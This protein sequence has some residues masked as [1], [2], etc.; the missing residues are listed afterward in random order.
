MPQGG[1]SYTELTHQVVREAAEPLGLD[2]IVAQVV[3]RAGSAPKN[4]K[5]TVRS[6]LTQS[7]AIVPLGDGRWGWRAR[8]IN[9]AVHR[10]ILHDEDLLEHEL[11][12]GEALRDLLMPTPRQ[13]AKYATKGPPVIELEGGPALIVRLG[14]GHSGGYPLQIGEFFWDWLAE[15]GARPGDSLLISAVDGEARRYRLRHEPQA[16][17][18]EATIRRRGEEVL[19]A[20]TALVRATDGRLPIWSVLGLLNARGAFHH[21]VPPEPFE[22]LWTKDVWGPLA[23]EL[24]AS[25]LLLGGLYADDDD[26]DDIGFLQSVLGLPEPDERPLAV[27]IDPAELPPGMTLEQVKARVDAL[28]KSP[29]PP[30]LAP[31]DPLLPLLG[32]VMAAAG[33]PSPTGQPYRADQL[34]AWFGDDPATL[35]WIA[36]GMALGMVAPDPAIEMGGALFAGFDAEGFDDEFAGDPPDLPAAYRRGGRRKP[37]PSAAGSKGPVTTYTLRVAYR[38]QPDFW[39]DIEIAAD[40][41]LEDLHLAI[42]QALD[43]DDDHLYSFYTGRRPYDRK[44]E[45]GSPWSEAKRHTH[46]VELGGLGLAK[47]KRLLYHFDYGDD[48]LFDIEVLGVNAAAPKGKYPK[49]VGRRGARLEQYPDDEGDWDDGDDEE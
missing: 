18:D 22:E 32:K 49:V 37:R 20:A 48:H 12:A 39:R 9:G 29:T 28:L 13:D 8:L 23:D 19:A 27:E 41:N 44:T 24:D 3:A 30:R 7:Q 16:A 21:P 45:I 43:W 36:D 40:Q 15:R 35:S 47:G 17:R 38:Y 25:P 2:A 33:L 42:Q 31:D 5:S 6:A 11:L 14:E 46:Q 34:I 4:P 10:A 26:D 1:P